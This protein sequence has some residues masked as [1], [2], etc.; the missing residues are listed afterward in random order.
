[1]L[2]A[3]ECYAMGMKC[4]QE[5]DLLE[6]AVKWFTYAAEQGHADAQFALGA[7]YDGG[8]GVERSVEL[9]V[10]WYSEG[11]KNGSRDAQ[12]SLAV[13]HDVGDGV[14]MSKEEAARWYLASAEQGRPDAQYMIGDCYLYGTGVEKSEEEA[15]RWLSRSAAP[16]RHRPASLVYP[17]LMPQAPSSVPKSSLFLF[18]HPRAGYVLAETMARNVSFSIACAAMSA[19]SRAVERCPF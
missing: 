15:R 9:A 4:I 18:R 10:K 17:V 3:D 13:C 7:C 2:T 5:P 19:R 6:E 12:F 16:T 1:M 14:E 11:A 8:T